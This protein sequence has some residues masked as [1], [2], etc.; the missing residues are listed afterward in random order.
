MG[1][2]LEILPA[3]TALVLFP[4]LVSQSERRWDLTVKNLA[5]VG[6]VMLV[7]CL[8]SAL[9]I[10]PFI[11]LAF[12]ERYL[13]AV[14]IFY[15]LLPGIFALSLATILSQY[16]AA[17]GFPKMLVAVW[18]LD[19]IVVSGL[20]WFLVPVY[21]GVGAAIALSVAYG[22]LLLMIFLLSLRLESERKLSSMNYIAVQQAA[23]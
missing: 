19:F 15:C 20:S 18:L 23:S 9:L 13:P 12:G 21:S 10:K 11:H 4:Y 7:F 8:A 2:V 14:P 17:A 3:S 16:I 6:S 5:F 1:N 22:I